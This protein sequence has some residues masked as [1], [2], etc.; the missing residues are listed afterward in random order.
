MSHLILSHLSKENNN[1][2]LAETLFTAH[3]GQTTVIA[4]SR[5]QASQVYAI[6]SNPNQ[7]AHPSIIKPLQLN[8]FAL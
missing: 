1:P 3:A 8:L 5:Y 6:E 4:A 2:Q 7:P